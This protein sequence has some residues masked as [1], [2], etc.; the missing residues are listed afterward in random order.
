MHDIYHWKVVLTKNLKDTF[1]FSN[2]FIFETNNNF[3]PLHTKLIIKVSFWI[4]AH[5]TLILPFK[6]D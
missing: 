6:F 5:R 1:L 3:K 4:E 2:K